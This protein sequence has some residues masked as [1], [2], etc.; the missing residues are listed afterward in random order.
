MTYYIQPKSSMNCFKARKNKMK[1][2][3]SITI[4]EE[5]IEQIEKM[6][7]DGLFRSKSHILE[8]SLTKFLKGEQNGK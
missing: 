3:L 1:Q 8:Y 2:K 6:L 7:E 5:K 4:D